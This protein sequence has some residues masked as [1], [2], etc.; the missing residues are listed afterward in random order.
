MDLPGVNEEKEIF[1]F[2]PSEFAQQ[3]G[4]IPLGRKWIIF[5]IQIES[6]SKSQGIMELRKFQRFQTVSFQYFGNGSDGWIEFW[7][8]PAL[9]GFPVF[10]NIVSRRQCAGQKGHMAGHGPASVWIGF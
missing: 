5:I 10:V 9:D 4:E 7:V 8:N 2:V 6:P 3:Y 1:I